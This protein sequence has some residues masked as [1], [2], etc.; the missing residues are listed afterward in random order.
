MP[1]SKWLE[2]ELKKSFIFKNKKITQIY[3][4]IDDE[5]FYPAAFP[6]INWPLLPPNRITQKWGQ[7]SWV[8]LF[9]HSL[10]TFLN[11]VGI[12]LSVLYGIQLTTYFE[13]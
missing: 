9:G 6:L 13:L 7:I 2:E 8:D 4:A 3:N 12:R 5:N 1:I 10:P 11:Y